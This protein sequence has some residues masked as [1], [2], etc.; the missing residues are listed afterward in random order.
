MKLL[1][2]S[3]D[4]QVIP[5]LLMSLG[6][7]GFAVM[8]AGTVADALQALREAA[9]DAVVSDLDLPDGGSSELLE[10]MHKEPALAPIPVVVLTASDDEFTRRRLQHAGAAA[11][12]TRPFEPARLAADL[13]RLIQTRR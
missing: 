2:V 13:S 3:S 11:V 4:P 6:M 1:V 10:A 5:V 9:P 12:V 7:A 8:T